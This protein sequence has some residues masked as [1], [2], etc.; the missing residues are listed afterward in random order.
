MELTAVINGLKLIPP[1]A[2]VAIYSDSKYVQ[3]G[4]TEWIR[5]WKANA[6]LTKR[7]TPVQNRD[8][9]EKLDKMASGYRITWHWV[10]GHSGHTENE[11]CDAMVWEAIQNQRGKK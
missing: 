8:L 4:M 9:W 5:D 3:K 6:W 10:R 11:R 2:N 1:E 7:G